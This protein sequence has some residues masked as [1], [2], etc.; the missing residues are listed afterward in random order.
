MDEQAGGQRDVITNVASAMPWA[1]RQRVYHIRRI[2]AAF[3]PS[4]TVCGQARILPN[5]H[6]AF[7][8]S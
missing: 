2:C 7:A 3:R 8:W 6:A 1:L 4:V 5:R